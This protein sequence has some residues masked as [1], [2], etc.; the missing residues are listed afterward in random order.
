MGPFTSRCTVMRAKWE[1]LAWAVALTRFALV[2]SSKL[3]PMSSSQHIKVVVILTLCG[4]T[5]VRLVPTISPLL[6]KRR[7]TSV[8]QGDI[9]KTVQTS[10]LKLGNSWPYSEPN[11]RGLA[12]VAGVECSLIRVIKSPDCTW[13]GEVYENKEESSTSRR[14]HKSS[15]RPSCTSTSLSCVAC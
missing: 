14:N 10:Q 15:T 3:S 9:A 5:L 2:N 6:E 7:S 1:Y 13:R 12:A 8:E 4:A 11:S